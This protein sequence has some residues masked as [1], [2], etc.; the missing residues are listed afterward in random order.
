MSLNIDS[1]SA[2]LIRDSLIRIEDKVDD[3]VVKIASLDSA[4][5]GH[6]QSDRDMHERLT[7]AVEDTNKRI[8][9]TNGDV[10]KV[11]DSHNALRIKVMTWAG[12]A[13]VICTAVVE[14]SIKAFAA[15]TG[16][17]H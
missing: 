15:A 1:F 2:Q 16:G 12:I 9:N 4:V 8:D 5:Q 17:G 11:R 6:V 13:A 7:K 3:G 14:G 10:R